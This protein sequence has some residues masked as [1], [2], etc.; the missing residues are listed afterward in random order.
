[1]NKPIIIES[2]DESDTIV[3]RSKHNSSINKL[4]NILDEWSDDTTDG[5]D[6]QN[7]VY[8]LAERHEHNLKLLDTIKSEFNIN[9]DKI[10]HTYKCND[11]YKPELNGISASTIA[12]IDKPY[13]SKD[14]MDAMYYRWKYS[15]TSTLC[16][17]ADESEDNGSRL[18]DYVHNKIE[19]ILKHLS[20]TVKIKD[21][22]SEFN[23]LFNL[24]V[25]EC[26]SDYNDCIK[27]KD[28]IINCLNGFYEN[29]LAYFKDL[30]I[31]AVE[32][33][34]VDNLM[35][36]A[37]DCIMAHYD[38]YNN[39]KF[40]FIDWKTGAVTG[41]GNNRITKKSLPAHIHDYTDEYS[42]DRHCISKYEQHSSQICIYITMFKYMLNKL[43]MTQ[44]FGSLS[45]MGF[46]FNASKDK[47]IK[48][49]IY[50][51]IN[52]FA[53]LKYLYNNKA[54]LISYSKY[55]AKDKNIQKK[56]K[57]HNVGILCESHIN[58]STKEVYYRKEDFIYYLKHAL[59]IDE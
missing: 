36:G 33:K 10:T 54:D 29:F 38:E 28:K 1:M 59:M 57:N 30:Y 7:S 55:I 34:L 5:E 37:V 53:R 13:T 51:I 44:K 15:I 32:L 58:Y 16:E 14:V 20:Y 31:F 56:I 23:V 41:C 46:I 43:N 47:K 3:K 24:C 8:T 9:I 22:L 27:I 35:F 48:T 26:I 18:G 40:I 4:T 42:Y 52:C 17:L 50:P 39:V 21:Q 49:Q 45:Y 2:D 25:K 6:E 12:T 19:Y 11:K